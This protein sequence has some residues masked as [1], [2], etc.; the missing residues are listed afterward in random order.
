MRS[1]FGMCLLLMTHSL[2][3]QIGE[4]IE[5]EERIAALE[6]P[7]PALTILH[8]RFPDVKSVKYYREQ[9]ADDISYEAKFRLDEVKY[10]V[11]FYSD[12]SLMDIEKLMAFDDIPSAARS[13][14]EVQW[15]KQFRKWKVIKCQEQSSD[16]GI[17]YEIEM[18]GKG[19]KSAQ[20]YEYL[21]EADGTFVAK[22]R[23]VLRSNDM[24]LY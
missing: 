23:L 2:L 11:E 17:R 6:F 8:E 24:S 13:A 9:S 7:V 22:S 15:E 12:G 10:S 5:I 3:A 18:K 19:N 14:I 16:A 1:L 4:K 20:L 21:F